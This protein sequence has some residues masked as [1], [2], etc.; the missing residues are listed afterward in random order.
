VAGVIRSA[1][2]LLALVNDVLDLSKIRAGKLP[3]RTEPVSLHEVAEGAR[4]TVGAIATQRA[5]SL[6]I[7]VPAS[8]PLVAGDPVRIQQILV[9][10]LSNGL[11]FTPAGGHVRLTA[12]V[13]GAFLSLVVADTGVGIKPEDF[14][15][16]FRDFERLES[17]QSQQADGTG[18]GLSLTK[19]LVELQ[20]GR[21]EVRSTPGAGSTFTVWLP[22]A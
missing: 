22:L 12:T 6:T 19:H 3:L 2:H 16:L 11:K 17:G 9:N 20:G 18:L 4:M 10:P 15:R 7:D 21:I 14:S 13:D 8:L 5:V 1:E